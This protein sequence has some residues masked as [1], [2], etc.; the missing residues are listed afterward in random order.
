MFSPELMEKL[1]PTITGITFG[2]CHMESRGTG[3]Q[4]ILANGEVI[5]ALCTR[6]G[7]ILSPIQESFI[8][9]VPDTPENRDNFAWGHSETEGTILLYFDT[10]EEFMYWFNRIEGI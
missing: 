7:A 10:I 3:W 1:M 6:M 4:D 5:G 9:C 2:E 8:R